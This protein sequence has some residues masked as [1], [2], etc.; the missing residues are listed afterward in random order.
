MSMNYS[1]QEAGRPQPQTT[2]EPA[3]A[4]SPFIRYSQPGTGPQYVVSGSALGST[5]TQP[6][7][8]RPG[9][10]RSLRVTQSLYYQGTVTTQALSADGMPAVNSLIQVRDSF[11]TPLFTVDGFTMA[12]IIPMVTQS[13]GALA[14]NNYYQNLPSYS[15]WQTSTETAGTLAG[16]F[17]YNIPFEFAQGIGC[18]SMANASLLPTLQFNLNTATGLLGSSFAGTA[19]TVNTSVDLNYWW[20]PEGSPDITPPGLGTTRQFQQV[21]LNPTVASNTSARLQAPRT[22]GYLDSLTF[23]A[24]DSNGNRQDSV[25]PTGNNGNNRLQLYVDGV[26]LNDSTWNELQDDFAIANNTN[27]VTV[28][29]SA[30][31]AGSGYGISNGRPVGVLSYNRKTSLSQVSLG[32]LDSGEQLLSTNPSTLIELNASPW[33]TFSNGPAT[34]QAVFGQIV[35]TGSIIQGLPEL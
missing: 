6:L 8:A 29:T 24:R 10:A 13:F 35:P 18:I 4:G 32:K 7:V 12:V 21:S 2:I 5:I 16:Q 15:A 25:F 33:G 26:P 1:A 17:S 11:G 23:I 30:N 27:G 22:G 20:L 3:A 28:P 34:I 14:G 31:T 9:Y 19:P